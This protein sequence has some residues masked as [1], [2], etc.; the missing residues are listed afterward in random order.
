[1]RLICLNILAGKYKKELLS[2]IHENKDSCDIFCF[3]EV[4]HKG[5]S[6]RPIMTGAEMNIF[7]EISEVLKDHTGYFSAHQDEEEGLAIFHRKDLNIIEHGEVF[8]HKFKN[9]MINNHGRELGRQVQYIKYTE[10]ENIYNLLNFHG[11]W[12]KQG[13]IDTPERIAQSQ[14]IIEFVSRLE[15]KVIL[16]SDLNYVPEMESLKILENHGLINLIKEHDIQSTRSSLYNGLVKYA[17]YIFISSD[18]IVNEFKVLHD[19]VSDHLPLY[20]EYL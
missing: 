13:K 1:M 10:G 17:D 12:D 19:T 11:L 16:A 8:V 18:V 20:V 14:K 15:G 2:F 7:N 4:F 5:K 9:A 3:Q 6:T